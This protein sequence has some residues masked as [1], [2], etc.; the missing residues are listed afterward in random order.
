MDLL[1]NILFSKNVWLLGDDHRRDSESSLFDRV[2][3]RE[4]HNIWVEKSGYSISILYSSN[5]FIF[6]SEELLSSFLLSF[7]GTHWVLV[8]FF[9]LILIW[10][11]STCIWQIIDLFRAF[12][13]QYLF[14][15]ICFVKLSFKFTNWFVF[16]VNFQ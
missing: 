1:H 15:S 4:F 9:P 8:I 3:H 2:L 13:C 10:F 16:D 5:G 12:N 7:C 6:E 11:F 14:I